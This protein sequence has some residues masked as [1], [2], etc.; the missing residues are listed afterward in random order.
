MIARYG[1]KDASG[2]FFIPHGRDGL[3]TGG[4]GSLGADSDAHAADLGLERGVAEQCAPP[5]LPHDTGPRRS[6]GV[7]A[8]IFR[9]AREFNAPIV[10]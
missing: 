8:G 3:A 10:G 7:A 6:T 5:H 2:D 1:Y 4:R 9:I